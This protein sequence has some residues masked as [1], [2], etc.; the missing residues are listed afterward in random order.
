MINLANT[1]K[2]VAIDGTKNLSFTKAT[3][4]QAVKNI[5]KLCKDYDLEP[6]QV[7]AILWV[8]YRDLEIN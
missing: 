8:T 1:G 5:N 7:Q 2:R 6:A 4:E 3:K